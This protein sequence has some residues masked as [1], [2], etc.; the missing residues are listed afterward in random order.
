MAGTGQISVFASKDLQTLLQALKQTEPEIRKQINKQTR[1]MALPVW[2][3]AT[4]GNANTRY[5]AGLARTAKVGVTAQNVFLRA[6][7]TGKIGNVGADII[8]RPIEFGAKREEYRYVKGKRGYYKRRTMRQFRL[9]RPRG[10]VIYP[11]A[12]NVIP[13]IASLWV[14]TSIR[15]IA[16]QIEKGA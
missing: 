14:Q 11:A 15:T 7:S 4:A 6:G 16:E 1:T 5:E 13:R 12:A 9:P 3:E 2:K 8:A 10:Y